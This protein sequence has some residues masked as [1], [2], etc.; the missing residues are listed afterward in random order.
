MKR[1][2]DPTNR[3]ASKEESIAI[4]HDCDAKTK[5]AAVAYYL[6]YST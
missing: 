4:N 5:H 1:V 2:W 6:S 3:R